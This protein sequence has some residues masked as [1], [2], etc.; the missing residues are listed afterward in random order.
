MDITKNQDIVRFNRYKSIESFNNAKDIT[1]STISIVKLDKNVMDIYLGRTQLTHS[2]FPKS[3]KEIRSLIVNLGNRIDVLKAELNS[4]LS[5][6][7]EKYNKKLSENI[8]ELESGLIELVDYTDKLSKNISDIN[9][10]IKSI[11]NSITSLQIEDRHIFEILD[12]IQKTLSNF[13]NEESSPTISD[14]VSVKQYINDVSNKLLNKIENNISEINNLKRKDT[15]FVNDIFDLNKSIESL[16][17]E[18][19]HI[20]EILNNIQ[21]VNKNILFDIKYLKEDNI[22][23]N[24]EILYLKEKINFITGVESDAF[25]ALDIFNEK[26]SKLENTDKEL[27]ESIDK[28]NSTIESG[29]NS[30]IYW[31]TL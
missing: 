17:I 9:I 21:S 15:T 6:I 31:M 25:D 4:N 2:G 20:F 5:S 13:T 19:N 12:K 8:S 11:K 30:K 27:Q 28:L 29:I 1:S 18:D 3:D 14:I 16:R 23:L 26:L 22:K 7:D 24:N 10:D